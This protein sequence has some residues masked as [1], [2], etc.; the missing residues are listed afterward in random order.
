MIDPGALAFDTAGNAISVAL[1]GVLWALLFLLAFGHPEFAESVGFGRRTFWLLVPGAFLATLALLPIAPIGSDWLAVSFAGAMFPLLVCGLA[2]ARFAP[3]VGRSLG[4]YLGLLALVG[5]VGLGF[6]LPAADPI[7]RA[8]GAAVG[9]T[10]AAGQNVL[11]VAV[12]AIA[13]VALAVGA[14]RSGP[15]RRVAAPLGLTFGVMAA[16][17]LASTAIPGVGIEESFPIFLLPPLLA[18]IAAGLIAPRVWPGAEGF[19]LPTAYLAS[20]FGV[21]VGADALRQPPLYGSGPSGLYTVGGAGVLDLVYLSGL[22]GLAAAYGTH[23]LLGRG[24]APV[25]P[26]LP[27]PAPGPWKVLLG[28]FRTGVEGDSTAALRGAS[29]A[30]HD[31]AVQSA[32]LLDLPPPDPARPWAALPVPGW[33]VSDDANLAAAAA[34]GAADGRE[35]YRGWLTARWMVQLGQ[36]LGARRFATVGQRMIAFVVDLAVVSAPALALFAALALATPGNLATLLDGVVYNAAA[37]GFVAVAYLYFVLAERLGGTSVGKWVLGLIVRDRALARPGL[38]ALLVRDAPLLGPLTLVGLGGAVAVAFLTKSGGAASIA[39][40]GLPLP[41]GVFAFAIML[42][43]VA[44]GIAL[45]GTVGILVMAV[46]SERQR[47]GDLMAGTW[48]LRRAPAPD[49]R[50]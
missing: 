36:E 22:L 32:R 17:F 39:I 41:T 21:L 42:A 1:P 47:L 37:F 28:A 46:T 5:G 3:P 24:Y 23:R 40:L 43:F 19:A 34:R 18:G 4:R 14:T 2:F 29:A 33:I 27:A 38:R 10:A 26:A 7:A 20:T 48:V 30:S 12:A 44:G 50:G 45:L 6:V 11:V 35:S 16:T 31:A 8:A 13:T 49:R 25:G 9:G 15:L